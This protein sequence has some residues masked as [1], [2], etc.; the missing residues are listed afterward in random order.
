MPVKPDRDGRAEPAGCLGFVLLMLQ[1]NKIRALRGIS[2]AD[3]KSC[4]IRDSLRP[5]LRW[6]HYR[7][8]I[9]NESF[10]LTKVNLKVNYYV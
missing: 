6:T 8:L 4:E 7:L 1:R 9:R 10:Y 3:N 5:E 2:P